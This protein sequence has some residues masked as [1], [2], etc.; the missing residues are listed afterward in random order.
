MNIMKF[1]KKII[2]IPHSRIK[3]KNVETKMKMHSSFATIP[4]V[5]PNKEIHINQHTCTGIYKENQTIVHVHVSSIMCWHTSMKHCN[6][7][8]YCGFFNIPWTSNFHSFL[9][10]IQEVVKIRYA[11]TN[12]DVHIFKYIYH[13]NCEFFYIYKIKVYQG[14]PNFFSMRACSRP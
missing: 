7:I 1:K 2:F 4:F 9:C 13:Q 6:S 10:Q 12:C 3:T 11:I 5:K 14:I 8:Y